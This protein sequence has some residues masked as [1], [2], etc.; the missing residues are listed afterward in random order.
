MDLINII[1][2]IFD[3]SIEHVVAL[4]HQIK[5]LKLNKNQ[6]DI[7]EDLYEQ[8]RISKETKEKSKGYYDSY[9]SLI[10]NVPQP[11]IGDWAIVKNSS[12]NKWY[13]YKCIV[14]GSWRNTGET[15]SQEIN[16]SG[17][18]KTSDFKTV[19]G[20]SIIGEG[21]IE[22]NEGGQQ[23]SLANENA[24]GLMSKE[25]YSSLQTIKNETLPQI[26]NDIDDILQLFDENE[27]TNKID[28]IIQ[29][30]NQI[31]QFIES[32][33]DS[34]GTQIL[35]NLSND[36]SD[37]QKDIES[38]QQNINDIE[39]ELE[40]IKEDNVSINTRLD[41][42]DNSIDEINGTFS[43]SIGEALINLTQ[44]VGSCENSITTAN[45]DI[46]GLDQDIEGLD[47]DIG[48]LSN[49]ITNLEQNP[50]VPDDL[51]TH[52]IITQSEYDNLQEYD[53]DTLYLIIEDEDWGFGDK[54]PVILT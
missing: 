22:I 30:Y 33:D 54:F 42:I 43:G 6:Q 19:N 35:I 4:A 18:T 25:S 32:L 40:D 51:L 48:E 49:R 2:T 37:L 16:L 31:S 9:Q 29:K 38:I 41:N 20:Q 47:Q 10:Q 15:Y 12:D 45:R 46:E 17:Y 23:Y 21:N 3:N 50:V 34:D 26:R 8:I 1:G 52:V 13:I 44:R 36:I 11:E 39:K 5:D 53:E 7:N 14:K 28:E 27:D 24:D